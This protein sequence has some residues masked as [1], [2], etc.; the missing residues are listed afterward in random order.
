MG[1]DSV[2]CFVPNCPFHADAVLK[3]WEIL[4]PGMSAQ[5]VYTICR[6]H[7]VDWNESWIKRTYLKAAQAIAPWKAEELFMRWSRTEA[8]GLPRD[9]IAELAEKCRWTSLT[10]AESD[11]RRQSSGLDP[12]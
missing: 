9:A 7:A 10:E 1:N 4:A 12:N 5:R 2:M 8:Q 3:P 6:K 11:L